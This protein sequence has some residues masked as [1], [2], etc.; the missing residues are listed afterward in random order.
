SDKDPKI[1]D[2]V[3]KKISVCFH[4]KKCY[5]T[6]MTCKKFFE[7]PGDYLILLFTKNLI[8]NFTKKISE[9]KI[10]HMRFRI[11]KDS[12]LIVNLGDSDKILESSLDIF[13]EKVRNFSITNFF[14]NLIGLFTFEHSDIYKKINNFY[15]KLYAIRVKKDGTKLCVDNCNFKIFSNFPDSIHPPICRMCA[16]YSK[17]NLPYLFGIVD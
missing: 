5:E 13:A 9:T 11:F 14:N 2:I 15:K 12:L 3:D 8:K 7:R 6:K 10:V 17:K 4:T 16:C 1:E